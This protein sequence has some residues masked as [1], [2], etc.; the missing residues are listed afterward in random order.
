MFGHKHLTV[1]DALVFAALVWALIL[2]P[3][4]R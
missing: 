3:V 1:L 2:Y 4:F